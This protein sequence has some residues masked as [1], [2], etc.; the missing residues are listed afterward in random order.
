MVMYSVN[1]SEVWPQG[2]PPQPLNRRRVHAR[3]VKDARHA[4][5][6]LHF[7]LELAADSGL[8]LVPGA[9]PLDLV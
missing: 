3:P 9:R 8:D 1:R 7:G 6:L 4:C 2:L 5:I